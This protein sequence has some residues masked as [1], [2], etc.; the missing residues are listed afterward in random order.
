MQKKWNRTL[1][2][3]KFLF[4]YIRY[5]GHHYKRTKH[6]TQWTENI[7]EVAFLLPFALTTSFL[8][9][10]LRF[11]EKATQSWKHKRQNRWHIFSNFLASHNV[12]KIQLNNFSG[13]SMTL[14]KI[15]TWEMPHQK[16]F[17]AHCVR[18]WPRLPDTI[19]CND[20]LDHCSRNVVHYPVLAK[21]VQ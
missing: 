11:S 6:T 15:Q 4:E 1:C 21:F 18:S 5:I 19:R 16:C 9:I 10:K 3:K 20:G 12:L 2:K 17:S 8:H 13:K 14:I 7:S